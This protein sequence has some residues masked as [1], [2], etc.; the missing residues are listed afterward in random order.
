[1]KSSPEVF[2]RNRLADRR[3]V[4]LFLNRYLCSCYPVLN[5][6][7]MALSHLDV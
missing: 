6:F 7:L 4:G 2:N 5:S 1:L 3:A